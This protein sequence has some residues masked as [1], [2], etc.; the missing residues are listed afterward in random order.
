MHEAY[1]PISL[2]I[3]LWPTR[4]FEFPR[5]AAAFGE[6]IRAQ[7][8]QFEE[9][10]LM[11]SEGGP[12][13]P[14][15]PCLVM[16]GQGGHWALELAPAKL[17]LRRMVET[18]AELGELFETVKTLLLPI[19]TW[20]AEN[21]NLRVCRLGALTQFFCDTRSS[22]NDKIAAYFLQP[23]ALQGQAPMEIQLGVLAR[24]A[25]DD[26]SIVNRWVRVQPLRTADPRQL[27][28]AAKIEIDLNTQAEDTH[29]RTG[30]DIAGFLDAVRKHMDERLP[31]LSDPDFFA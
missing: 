11:Q 20:M 13:P 18:P 15:V 24:L 31:L 28:L 14:E 12:L 21:N 19:H 16:I 2:I 30:R 29:V 9:I 7:F 17:V 23:R 10:R 4:E 1:R 3:A 27:D 6:Q 26:G 22:A 25:L 8:G 5:D